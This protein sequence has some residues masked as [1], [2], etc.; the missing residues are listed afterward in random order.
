MAGNKLH[1]F[2]TNT[3]KVITVKGLVVASKYHAENICSEFRLIYMELQGN[4]PCS[5]NRILSK[6]LVV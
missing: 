6:Y 3:V 2:S 4:S 1:M 5:C